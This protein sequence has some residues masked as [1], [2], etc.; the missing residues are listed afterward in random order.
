MHDSRMKAT[1]TSLLVLLALLPGTSAQSRGFDYRDY[2]YALRTYV[3]DSGLVDYAGLKKDRA[4]LDRFAASLAALE[5]SEYEAWPDREKIAFWINVYNALTLK[6]VIDNYPIEPSFWASLR[7]P[8]NSIRQIS[9]AWDRMGFT[10]IGSEMTLDQME[11]ETLRAEFSEPR[12]HMALVCAAMGC[13]PLRNEPYRADRLSAQLNDQTRGFL[14]DPV[15]FR[16]DRDKGRV[17]LSSIFKWYGE[18]FVDDYGG[19]KGLGGRGDSEQAVLSFV[20]RYLEPEDQR[21]LRGGDYDIR[22]LGY[23]WSLNEQRRSWDPGSA[24]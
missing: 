1:G 7:F 16:I 23:D 8:K 19:E 4:P 13:P 10:V 18:D 15:K 21:Y 2:E 9:G 5:R 6:L 14:G 20:S 12:I 3:D 24:E 11:H 22:Y 17:H